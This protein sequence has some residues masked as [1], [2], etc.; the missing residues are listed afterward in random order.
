[1]SLS[2]WNGVE[3]GPWDDTDLQFSPEYPV[4]APGLR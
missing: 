4:G 3:G 2:G 1:M